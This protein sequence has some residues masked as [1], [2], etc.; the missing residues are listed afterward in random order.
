MNS[1]ERMI[2]TP[3]WGLVRIT[4][5][6]IIYCNPLPKFESVT[7][8]ILVLTLPI[9][10]TTD[11]RGKATV[12]KLVVYNGSKA[13]PC[14]SKEMV[15]LILHCAFTAIVDTIRIIINIKH[16]RH[17]Y[18]HHHPSILPHHHHITPASSCV[19][20]MALRVCDVY[21]MCGHSGDQP[22]CT[23]C[24]RGHRVHM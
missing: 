5:P 9:L 16:H 24:L 19:W 20:I 22:E 7:T 15:L 8:F 21:R 2:T 18:H 10:V 3:K 17:H 11:R 23:V 6:S 4:W 1:I 12:I 13:S 14:L